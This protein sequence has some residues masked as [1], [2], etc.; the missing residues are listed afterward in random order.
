MG[1]GKYLGVS[2]PIAVSEKD[3]K[4]LTKTTQKPNIRLLSSGFSGWRRLGRFEW[5]PQES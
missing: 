4:A 3:T 2:E 1:A 5:I